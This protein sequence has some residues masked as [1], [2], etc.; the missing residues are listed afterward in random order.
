MI[1]NY[2]I[3]DKDMVQLKEEFSCVDDKGDAV[4]VHILCELHEIKNILK[5]KK[6]LKG[7]GNNQWEIE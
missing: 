1:G 3:N 5:H 6:M 2:K 4:L 7:R